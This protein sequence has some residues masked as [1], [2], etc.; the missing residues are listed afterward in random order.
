M[1]GKTVLVTGANVGIGLETARGLAA[2]G[3]R[4]L[5]AA[6]DE[7]KG[8]AAAEDVRKSTGGD[9]SMVLL[10]LARRASI[11]GA[12]EALGKERIDVLINN[13]GLILSER[14][15][16]AEGFE[17][18]FGVNHLGHFL[19]TLGLLDRLPDGARVVNVSS[20][21]HRSSKGLDFEDLMRTR[22]K[23]ASFPAYCDSKLAN[24][25]FTRGLVRRHPRLVAHSLHPGVVRTGFARDGDVKGPIKL[26]F[27]LIRPFMI[28]ARKGAETSIHVASSTRGGETNGKYWQRSAISDPTAAAQ[29][30]EAADRLWAISAELWGL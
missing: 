3:A 19:L 13:A 30:D 6:R 26:L 5:M 1:E 11:E 18:T 12:V 21:A 14:S 9:A 7:A 28:P 2:M 8:R 17:T 27:G 25:L 24:I 23:Y 22:R 15:E 29:D 16:T 10:D 20:E 4:V